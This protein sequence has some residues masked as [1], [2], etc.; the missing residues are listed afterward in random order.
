MNRKLRK[1]ASFWVICTMT[2]VGFF[3]FLPECAFSLNNSLPSQK[4][5]VGVIETP[6]LYMK[7]ADNQWEGLGVDIW[8]TVAQDMGVLFEFR[9][10]QHFGHLLEAIEK[11]EIDITPSLP[12]EVRYEQAM[13]LSQSYF[14]SGLAISV[15]MGDS[16]SKWIGIAEKIFS[17]DVLFAI[18]Q[19]VLLSMIA[20]TIVFLFERRQNNKMFGDRAV[21]GIGQGIW[22]SVVTMT[23]VGYGDKAPVS[24]GG[25]IVAIIWML[26][27]VVFIAGFTANITSSLTVSELRGKVRGFNDL[28]NVRVGA[29]EQSEA[30]NFL[31]KHGIA[32]IPFE[33]VK[34][35]LNAVAGKNIDAF[36]LNEHMLKYAIKKDFQGRVQVLPGIYDEYFVVIGLKK[37]HALR[38]EINKALLKLMKTEK[39]YDI[40]NRY[41]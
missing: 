16:D 31:S 21:Q 33:S 7:T 11:G 10:Y 19:L 24:M 30:A 35:G 28:H 25:R 8:K 34:T 6:P 26:F 12:A 23:T 2:W 4:I 38:K 39:W 3:L 37:E 15:A 41:L 18:G 29:I 17:K 1:Q 22:W 13:D 27:S 20:G 9:E 14:K 36:V 32:I 5:I 40:L